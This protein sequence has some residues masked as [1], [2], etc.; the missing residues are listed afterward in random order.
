MKLTFALLLCIPAL[1]FAGPFEIGPFTGTTLIDFGGLG[2]F[3][4]ITTQFQAQGFSAVNLYAWVGDIPNSILGEPSALN[5]PAPDYQVWPFPSVVLNFS[6][7]ITRIDFDVY[8]NGGTF[9]I[10]TPTGEL[11][12]DTLPLVV[13][14]VGYEDP[15]GFSQVTLTEIDPVNGA[16][17]VSH[18]TFDQAAPEPASYVLV[19]SALLLGLAAGKRRLM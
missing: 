12:Y 10:A 7:P 14:F 19:T 16:L 1:S 18:L 13:R 11:T 3:E 2:N 15:A 5:F 17:G 8:T 4:P 9:H 6:S